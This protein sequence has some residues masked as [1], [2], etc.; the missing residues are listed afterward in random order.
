MLQ[1][2]CFFYKLRNIIII[3]FVEPKHV[4]RFFKSLL[5]INYKIL[6]A[7]ISINKYLVDANYY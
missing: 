7:F 1:T 2:F 6:G 5:Y 4:F 3:V